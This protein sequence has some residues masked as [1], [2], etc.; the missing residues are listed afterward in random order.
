MLC[1]RKGIEIIKAKC[2][3]DHIHILVRIPPK[4]SVAQIMEYIKEKSSLMILERYANLKYK[5][6]NKHF[7]CR[8]YYIDKVEKNAKKI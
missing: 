2:C 5:F 6:E 8:G 3:K 7:G 1:K 4:Y